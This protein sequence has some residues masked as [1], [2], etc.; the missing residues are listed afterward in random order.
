MELD[1]AD[2]GGTG[3]GAVGVDGAEYQG[4]FAAPGADVGGLLIDGQVLLVTT[5]IAQIGH[6]ARAGR[7]GNGTGVHFLNL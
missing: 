1:A 7:E 5:G 2:G 4:V 3:H 6:D